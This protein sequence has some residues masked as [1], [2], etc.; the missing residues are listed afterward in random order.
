MI[1]RAQK[2]WE[3]LLGVVGRKTDGRVGVKRARVFCS[4]EV[5]VFVF[6]KIGM[7]RWLRNGGD[8]GDS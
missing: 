3:G 5:L 7:V 8:P 6:R 1:T 2:L 4:V